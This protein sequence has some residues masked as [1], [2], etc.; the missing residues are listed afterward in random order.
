MSDA[1][2]LQMCNNFKMGNELECLPSG[3]SAMACSIYNHSGWVTGAKKER[4]RERR[5]G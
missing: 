3:R 2:A 5:E 1:M 4:E